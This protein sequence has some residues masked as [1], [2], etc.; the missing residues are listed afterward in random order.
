MMPT[1]D[2]AMAMSSI[3]D[4][5]EFTIVSCY[6]GGSSSSPPKQRPQSN[7]PPRQSN[8]I[9]RINPFNDKFLTSFPPVGGRATAPALLADIGNLSNLNQQKRLEDL[10]VLAPLGGSLI[11]GAGQD[12]LA[13]NTP[14]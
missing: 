11:V 4:T 7:F 3:T 8:N 9:K 13:K 6:G 12:G 10:V 1:T 14:Q 5:D 2:T